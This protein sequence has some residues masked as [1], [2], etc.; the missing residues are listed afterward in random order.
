[1]LT[2]VIGTFLH[3]KVL[4]VTRHSDIIT[5]VIAYSARCSP[6]YLTAASLHVNVLCHQCGAEED[7]IYMHGS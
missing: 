5:Y 3:F 2:G 6:L 7:W 4:N 1:M